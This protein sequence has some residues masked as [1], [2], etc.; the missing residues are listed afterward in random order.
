ML[1][2]RT[3]AAILVAG[4]LSSPAA[5]AGGGATGGA[6]EVTQML[7]NGLLAKQLGEQTAMV[8]QEVMT[9]TNTLNQY[10]TMLE[11]MKALPE[12]VM[13]EMLSLFTSDMNLFRQ[14][15]GILYDVQ[16]SAGEL[17][18]LYETRYQDMYAMQQQ[19]YDPRFYQSRELELA[20]A[21]EFAKKRLY[22]DL[23][24]LQKSEQRLG[25]IAGMAQKAP[26]ITST[27]GGFHA[28]ATIAAAQATEAA[29]LN[30]S[31]REQMA[32]DR[33]TDVAAAQN[34]KFRTDQEKKRIE[35]D[36]R[37]WDQLRRPVTR[38]SDYDIKPRKF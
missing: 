1:S 34:E 16:N 22:E 19:G 23:E 27:I 38:Q 31:V 8:A 3:F 6:T 30:K 11:D 24:S 17:Q 28:L 7:N 25:Q 20:R 33:N 9:A 14:S 21:D 18:R 37:A 5:F 26:Q 10:K 15:S 36:R 32:L 2:K 4:A 12:G 35:D 29:E 13:G